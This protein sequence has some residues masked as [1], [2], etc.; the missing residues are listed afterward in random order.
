MEYIVVSVIQNVND[1][2]VD[3][4]PPIV[5]SV[6]TSEMAN[7]VWPNALNQN[8]HG[9]DRVSNVMKHVLDAPDRK[10]QSANMGAKHA[11]WQ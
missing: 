11:K 6:P 1:H 3:P 10:I 2:V 8:M 4:M 5:L 9:M 7:I